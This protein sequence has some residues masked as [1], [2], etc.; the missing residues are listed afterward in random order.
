MLQAAEHFLAQ[1]P[2]AHLVIAGEG[3]EGDALRRQAAA[4]KFSQRI[5]LP[6]ALERHQVVQLFAAADLFVNP[7][8]DAA[9]GFVETLGVVTLEA[10]AM[11][12]PGVGTLV[13]GI[14]ETIIHGETGLLVPPSDPQALA[15]ALEGLLVDGSRRQAY[16]EAARRRVKEQ[17]SWR[18]LGPQ[19]YGIYEQL[20]AEK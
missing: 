19:V 5:H 11:G 18:Y 6:G 14:P 17:F 12:V 4:S 20:M 2:D 16:G 1:C 3:P 8:I 13:G 9:D 10:A 15:D 7:S